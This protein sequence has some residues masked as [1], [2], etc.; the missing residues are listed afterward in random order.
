[1]DLCT[2]A[3]VQNFLGATDPT[4]GASTLQQLVSAASNFVQRYIGRTIFQASYTET[5]NGNGSNRLGLKQRPISAI[6]SVTDYGNMIPPVSSPTSSGYALDGSV[7][8]LRG[9]S[10]CPGTQNIEVQYTAGYPDGTVSGES[11]NVSATAPYQATLLQGLNLRAITSLAYAAGGALTQVASNPARG[12]YTLTGSIL[13][14]NVA[15]AGAALVASY[16]TNGTPADLSEAVVEMV[17]T[18]FQKRTRMDIRSQT[19][20]Q[21]TI[22]FD[23]SQVPPTAQA[24]LNTYK[25]YWLPG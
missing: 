23:M 5:Y 10:F 14:F 25:T 12:Q 8:C 9:R 20:A 3:Q 4:L 7:L 19:I 1:M 15:D 17:A 21:Q 18:K 22:A 11:L 6:T 16:T 24:V 13:G 2:V